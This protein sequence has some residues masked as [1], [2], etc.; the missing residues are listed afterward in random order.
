MG[1]IGSLLFSVFVGGV[2]YAIARHELANLRKGR[3]GTLEI[4][5]VA[6]DQSA[7]GEKWFKAADAAIRLRLAM[8]SLM[9]IIGF[10]GILISVG[11]LIARIFS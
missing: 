4:D 6:Y 5:G 10:V 2:G 3:D 11:G 1:I 9:I 7:D 8:A